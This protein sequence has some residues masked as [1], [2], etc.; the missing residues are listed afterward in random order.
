[1]QRRRGFTLVELLIVIAVIGILTTIATIT[2]SSVKTRATDT[3]R[4]SQAD[5]IA[6]QL[7]AYYQKH[8]EYPGCSNITGS[9]NDVITNTLPRIQA[10]T[11][12]APN[13]SSGETNSI[14]C[15]DLTSLSQ[16]DYFAYV[17]DPSPTCTSGGACLTYTIKYRDDYDQKIVSISS[18][19]QVN[20]DT[21]G[22]PTLTA[23]T[24]DFTHINT[25]WSSVTSALSYTLDVATDSNFTQNHTS[26]DYTATSASVS[27]L[28]MGTTYYFRVRVNAASGS[29]SWSNVTSVSTWNLSAPSLTA[30]TLSSTSFNMSWTASSHATSYIL[31]LSSDGTTWSSGWQY[32]FSGTSNT[33]SSGVAQGYRYYGRV[34]AVNGSFSGPW[35]N[36]ANTTT[37]IDSPAAYNIDTI[38]KWDSA[39][40]NV[41][42]G[43]A[44][45]AICPA[46]TTPSYDWYH[47]V[48]GTNSFWV[49]GTQYQIVDYYMSWNDSVSLSVATRCITSVASSSFVWANGSASA[50][51]PWPSVS[52]WLSAYRTAA[53][54][55]SCPAWT[56]SSA[57]DW[58]VHGTGTVGY[59]LVGGVGYT[60]WNGGAYTWGDGDIRASIHCY[61]PWGDAR[62]DSAPAPFGSG[63]VPTI[64]NSYCT[65]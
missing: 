1:M 45:Q 63:C 17:G 56:T 16:S 15:Q 20:I 8:G 29:G 14:K 12:V 62:A 5:I 7:E 49:S 18:Q 40:F 19:H 53:W 55:G 59:Q 31:Q 32:S 61:G 3:E 39:H 2:Y 47:N 27:G 22:V 48:N 43:S 44:D 26:T 58:S 64:T 57:Y 46:G 60:S 51:L 41:L 36:I 13:D 30:S 50:S 35:S 37:T 52:A 33:F 6:K 54:G 24:V 10:Q 38:Q 28:S 9:A 21:S 4:A 34:Q 65:W 11:L 25:S 23:S 42:R